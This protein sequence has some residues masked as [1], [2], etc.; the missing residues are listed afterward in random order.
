MGNQDRIVNKPEDIYNFLS[1]EGRKNCFDF[2]S[3][4]FKCKIDFGNLIKNNLFNEVTFKNAIFEKDVVFKNLIFAGLLSFEQTHFIGSANFSKSKFETIADFN[5]ANFNNKVDFHLSTFNDSVYFLE[6]Y[7]K[8]TVCFKGVKIYGEANFHEAIFE[9]YVDFPNAKFKSDSNFRFLT[10]KDKVDFSETKFEGNADFY[11]TLFMSKAIFTNAQFSG[12][13]GFVSAYF[14][15]LSFF[16]NT[17]FYSKVDFFSAIFDNDASFHSTQFHGL[18]IFA[19]VSF[20]KNT[21]FES[22][23]FMGNAT[24]LNSLF[25]GELNI[26]S[27]AIFSTHCV[28]QGAEI[29]NPSR[30]IYCIRKHEC[31]KYNN[32][33][34]ALTFHQ[35]EMH[36]YWNELFGD[37]TWNEIKTKNYI[38]K[39]LKW[40]YRKIIKNFDEKFVLFFNRYSNYFGLSWRQGVLFTLFYV[41]IPFFLLYLITLSQPYFTL[42]WNGWREFGTVL[43]TSL[44]YYVQFLNPAHSFY[45]MEEFKPNPAGLA[46]VIDGLSR[47]FI[48]F[49]YY[50]TIQAFR[51]YRF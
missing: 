35:K 38:I 33:I 13:T 16:I 1:E 41:G 50:Q 31:L 4:T 12:D 48:T 43:D 37:D 9:D 14:Q 49:G 39:I 10:F 2:S 51:K 26:F 34:D 18:A 6:A 11:N 21:L 27:G 17:K 15:D 29:H 42:E 5:K 40:L 25:K 23:S 28:F 24:F 30:E 44:K 22:S 45:F 32:R 19:K 8:G 46:Y 20:L 36:A 3:V 7:F 47:I